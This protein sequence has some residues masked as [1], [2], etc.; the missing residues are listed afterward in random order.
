MPSGFAAPPAAKLALIIS[1]AKVQ[2]AVNVQ[3]S[4]AVAAAWAR[5][6][7]DFDLK[8]AKCAFVPW[9]MGEGKEEDFSEACEDM[10]ASGVCEDV[11]ADSAEDEDEG[12][13]H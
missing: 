1:P 12:G 6:D 9:H 3:S 11:G 4:T 5:L 13:K 8:C 10:A 7:H 2:W